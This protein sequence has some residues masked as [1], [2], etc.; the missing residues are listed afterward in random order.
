MENTDTAKRL[1]IGNYGSV[2]G[3]NHWPGLDSANS[4]FL[5]AENNLVFTT[6]GGI[7]F[8]GSTTAEH[9]RIAPSGNVS[10]GAGA[11]SYK[12]HVLNNTP[13]F[14]SAFFQ[15]LGAPAGGSLGVV[16]AAG[17][18]TNDSPLVV[19]SQAN[20]PFFKIRG[21]GNVGIGTTNPSALLEVAGLS[22]LQSVSGTGGQ[23]LFVQ[24]AMH[25]TGQLSIGTLVTVGNVPLC[26]NGDLV[27]KCSSSSLRYKTNVGTFGRGLDL[28]TRLRPSTFTWKAD[29][30]DDFGLIA[31]EVEK[32][33]PELV[34]YDK[35]QVDGVRY[36]RIGVVL[37]NAVKE[38]QEQIEKQ[39]R[40]ITS[41]QE[42][43]RT[44]QSLTA[45]LKVLVC[46]LRP[47]LHICKR[48][49]P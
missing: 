49:E 27:T 26:V 38:Q 40:A 3:G 32:E 4:S 20:V 25:V 18:N 14:P 16:I 15:T 5:Y 48:G 47:T 29:G 43:L 31:E 2:G 44:Q 33:A 8:S 10:I 6:P 7:F 37:I 34:Y 22:K 30:R 45:E 21:D 13:N 11:T 46:E 17:T 9:M 23:A 36:D 41:L 1:Y 19:Q 39:N 28:I 35:G 42:E 12:F 24:G